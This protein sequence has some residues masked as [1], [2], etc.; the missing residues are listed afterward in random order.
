MRRIQELINRIL[1]MEVIDGDGAFRPHFYRWTLF[2]G[3]GR[4]L[5]LHHFVSSDSWRD[6]HDHPRPFTSI[7]LKGEYVEVERIPFH[8][9]WRGLERAH[10]YRAPW[11]RS[12]GANHIHRIELIPD[13]TG[14]EGDCW[15]LV[16]VGPLECNWGFHT[17]QGWVFW[18]DYVHDMKN[19]EEAA[20]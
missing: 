5:Y 2:R 18:K 19:R 4:A 10:R 12:F 17:S 16:W 20:A 9:T 11:F 3:F 8:G 7:G 15:T 13:E 14:V 6:P 1:R